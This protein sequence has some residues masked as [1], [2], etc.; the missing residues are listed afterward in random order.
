MIRM[1]SRLGPNPYGAGGFTVVFGENE[2]ILNAAVKCDR[3]DI[4]GAADTQYGMRV[5]FGVTN[6]VTIMVISAPT[7][8]GPGNAFAEVG[9]IDLSGRTFTVTADIE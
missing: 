6:T 5:A 3:D 7:N 9:G 4:F 8:G 1:K 2:K